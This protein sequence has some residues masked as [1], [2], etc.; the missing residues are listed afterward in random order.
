MNTVS[1]NNPDRRIVV[2]GMSV[3]NL[4]TLME[5]LIEVHGEEAAVNMT[6][7][8]VQARYPELVKNL[9]DERIIG[10]EVVNDKE[11][12]RM[13]V[14]IDTGTVIRDAQKKVFGG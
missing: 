10:G 2:R 12:T 8:E 11:M 14:A 7:L 1:K 4:R 9:D 13:E 3:S 5:V 6:L